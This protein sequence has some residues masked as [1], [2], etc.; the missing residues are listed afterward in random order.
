[1]AKKAYLGILTEIPTYT[2]ELKT[3]SITADNISEYFDVTNGSY[4][5]AGSGGTFTS[6]NGGVNSST[7]TTTLKA[8]RDIDDIVFSYSYSSEANYDKFTLKVAGTTVENAVSGATTSKSYS[9]SLTAGQIVEFTYAKDSSQ[10]SNDDKCT[11]S[12]MTIKVLVKTQTSSETKSVARRCTKAYVGV[13]Q[14]SSYTLASNGTRDFNDG[15]V[16]VISFSTYQIN[17][18]GEIVP[19]DTTTTTLDELWQYVA[20]GANDLYFYLDGESS[21]TQC[22]QLYDYSEDVLGDHTEYVYSTNVYVVTGSGFAQVARKIKKAYIG[23]PQLVETSVSVSDVNSLSGFWDGKYNPDGYKPTWDSQNDCY[24]FT[25]ASG[26]SGTVYSQDFYYEALEGNLPENVCSND[27]YFVPSSYSDYY[28]HATYIDYT[29][30]QQADYVEI[31][32]GVNKSVARL[33]WSSVDSVFANN[34]W[35]DIIAACESGSVPDTWAVGDQKTMTINGADYTIDIIGKNH[36]TYSDGSG[37][38]PLTFQLHDC[39][40]TKYGMNSSN[41]NSGGWSSC[42]MRST[43]LPAILALM[44]SEVQSGIKEVSKKTSA[45]SQSTTINITADKL[46]LLS[47][48]EILGS[49]AS[50]SVAGEGTQ[51]KYYADGNSKVKKFNGSEDYWWERSP[52][53]SNNTYFCL[54]STTGGSSAVSASGNYGVAFAFCF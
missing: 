32:H 54:V 40:G 11:F 10:S 26:T 38:A 17:S 50:K 8:K 30:S 24:I 4:Y 15:S 31:Y 7:A 22:Y 39:Y 42:N 47:E 3:V 5:F 13:E 35:A 14:A 25:T 16:S 45:G 23:I 2:E 6:N 49:N 36:D 48:V 41:T 51:Y 43:T 33:C 12:G 52:R 46:F 44:P 19:S 20:S 9:G 1:M 21:I 34:T 18:D 28:V 29:Q 37:T 27:I 53:S